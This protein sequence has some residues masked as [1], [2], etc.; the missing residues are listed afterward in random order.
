M[1]FGYWDFRGLGE[2]VRLLLT[3]VG[4]NF[5][6]KRYKDDNAEE[7]TNDKNTLGLEFPNLPYL[8][9]GKIKLTESMAIMRYLGRKYGLFPTSDAEI[10]DCDMLEGVANDLRLRMSVL[11]YLVPNTA[12]GLAETRRFCSE[13]VDQIEDFLTGKKFVVGDKLTYVDFLVY[14]FLDRQLILFAD[15]LASK[16]R[17]KEYLQRFR[18]LGPIQEY[19]NSAN[20]RKFPI[21]GVG[22]EII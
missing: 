14:E 22:R 12:D 8:I 18:S 4:D 1:L 17:T 20:Y 7:W 5:L 19:L 6:D 13:K 2:P 9:D 21:H 15:I 3:Y 10:R 11:A 16:T